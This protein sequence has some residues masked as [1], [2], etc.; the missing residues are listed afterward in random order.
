MPR[1]RRLRVHYDAIAHLYDRQPYRG[2]TIDPE[3]LA[4]VALRAPLAGLS[5]LDV[6]CGTGNQVV[7]NRPVVPHA[8]LVGMDRSLGMLR[9]AQPKAPD[10][11]WIQAD[12]DT[13]PFRM[14]SFDFITCQYAFHHMQDKAGMLREVFRVLR[15]GG[16]FVL[17]NICPQEMEDWLYYQ[18]FPEAQWCDY[19]NFWPPEVVL[20]VMEAVGFVTGTAERQHLRYEQDLQVWLDMVQRRETCSQ[21]LTI[22]DAAYEAGVRRLASELAAAHT[23]LVRL[24]HV[25]IVSIRGEKRTDVR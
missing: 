9:Q 6:G 20:A 7:A 15:P 24:D 8:R 13:L 4:F 21:L 25:C 2:K 5:M 3:L 11:P 16:R 17:S 12:S 18:Y 14:Q 10:L 23:P 1:Q 22:P 19:E